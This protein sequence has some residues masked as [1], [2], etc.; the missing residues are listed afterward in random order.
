MKRI[1]FVSFS[2]PYPAKDGK[3]QRT[4]AILKALVEKYEVDFLIIGHQEDFNQAY[5][6]STTERINFF[7]LPFE[8]T[9]Y[10]QFLHRFGFTFIPSAYLINQID[11][12]CKKREYK[13]VFSRYI[14]PVLYLPGNLPKVVDIDD[15]WLEF[16]QTKLEQAKS[17]YRKFRLKQVILI[18]G[19]LYRKLIEKAKIGFLVKPVSGLNDLRILPNLPFQLLQQGDFSFSISLKYNLLFVGKLTYG[20]NLKGI[21]WFIQEV[22]P[23][24]LSVLPQVSLTIVSNVKVNDS[25]FE[26]FKTQFPSIQVRYDVDDLVSVY[27]THSIS[28]AP[29]FEGSGS[30]IKVAESILMGRPVV[31]TPFGMR[32]FEQIENTSFLVSCSNK[33]IFSFTIV[34]WLTNPQMLKKKQFQ[35]YEFGRNKYNLKNWNRDLLNQ[36]EHVG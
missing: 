22:Y 19:A 13:F 3:R 15:D 16:Y 5:K 18:N 26:D 32:G 7:F 36:L 11:A 8:R 14:H 12:L 17:K 28:I 35:A 9:W 24:I 20:P 30:N 23:I 31:A 29:I 4:L 33:E 1:L 6:Y 27:K 25:E 2:G 10:E 34:D 21:K